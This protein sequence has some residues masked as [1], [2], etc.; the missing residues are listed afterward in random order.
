MTTILRN[1]LLFAVTAVL[2]AGQLYGQSSRTPGTVPPISKS[3]LEKHYHTL[4]H[5][6]S[7]V[8]VELEDSDEQMTALLINFR[9]NSWVLDTEFKQNAAAL[10]KMN[11]TISAIVAA[12][13][14]NKIII[15]AGASPE[16]SEAFN[17]RVA[18]NRALEI[19]K[20]ILTKHPEINR[21]II[22]TH[23]LGAD[24]RGFRILVENDPFIPF[25][26]EVLKIID[27]N[28]TGQRK[29]ALISGLKFGIPYDYIRQNIFPRLRGG[30]TAIFHNENEDDSDTTGQP[31]PQPPVTVTEEVRY[32]PP[33]T[34]EPVYIFP[35]EAAYPWAG[36]SRDYYVALK[37]NLLY[38]LVLI[39]NI[40][41]EFYLGRKL[42]LE[43]DY[44]FSRWTFDSGTKFHRVHTGGIELR[45]WFGRTSHTPLNGHFLGVYGIIG[46][47]NFKFSDIGSQSSNLNYSVGVT[48]GYSHPIGRR[49]NLEAAIG[50]GYVGGEYQKYTKEEGT[51]CFTLK[52]TFRRHYFGPTKL[53]LSLVWLI[54]SGVNDR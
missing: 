6:G 11:R 23:S 14:M 7:T 45:K 22:E 35:Q 25:R 34:P 9:V 33:V 53:K 39:P 15:V 38:D 46:K 3:V 48:Y 12:N 27:S 50:V 1:F 19:R 20:Y 32:V 47:Y 29:I 17:E 36:A 40:G 4:L 37:T 31:Q 5:S 30:A 49:L 8:S 43:A 16:G 51:E 13:S 52:G 42:S 44:H 2:G 18:Y 54:G 24:W 10:E 28:N 26:E 41:V 21:N